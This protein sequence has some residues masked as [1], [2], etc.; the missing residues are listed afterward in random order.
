MARRKKNP[1][2]D[3]NFILN[4]IKDELNIRFFTLD[5]I[6]DALSWANLGN[7]AIH[8][9]FKSKRNR[10]YHVICGNKENLLHFCQK[11]DVKPCNIVAS[12][13]YRFWH[14]DWS[15]HAKATSSTKA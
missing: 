7:I 10:S 1:L 13:F 2:P 4:P 3:I 15:P 8:E 5:K 12:E 11:V 9:N 14:L 6:S